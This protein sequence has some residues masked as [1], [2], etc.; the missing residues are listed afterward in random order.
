VD[1]QS[2]FDFSKED[3]ILATGLAHGQIKVWHVPSGRLMLIL[4]DHKSTV[5]SLVFCPNPSS[6]ILLSG[7]SDRT[8]KVWNLKQDGNMT[9]TIDVSPYQ[10]RV[11]AISWS[12]NSE[13]IVSVGG[14]NKIYI[15]NS[16][17]AEREYSMIKSL[18]GHLNEIVDCDHSSDGALLI[19][20]SLDSYVIL[21]D[22]YTFQALR[23]FGHKFP[24]PRPI[25][26][27]GPNSH[28]VR[29]VQFI[30]DNHL[31]CSVADD[32]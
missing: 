19:T 5:N 27:S 11:L 13:R 32:G 24:P 30:S 2:R 7:S 10:T 6:L 25:F 3:C 29:G 18:S 8:M 31:F 21:W 12:P 20:A 15:W 23:K 17:Y 26:A 1:V 9:P 4:Y 14:S 16:L 28:G 22:P